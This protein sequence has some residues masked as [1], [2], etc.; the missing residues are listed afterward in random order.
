MRMFFSGQWHDRPEKI[1]VTNPYSGTVID[2]VPRGTV[3]DV[4]Q[5]LAT[6]VDGAKLMRAM[7]AY[8][9]SRI[10]RKAAA[11]MLEREADLGRTVSTEEGKILAEGIFEA[12]RARETIDV[13]AD[14]AKRLSSEV[15]PLDAA[16]GA[17]GKFGFTLRVPC[18]IVAAITPFNFP[19]NLVAHK[20]GPAIAAGNAVI[21]KPAS[22]TP[23]SA[24]KLVEILLEA[25]MPPQAIACITGGGAEIG[26]AL[27]TDKRVRKISFT[28]S[29]EVGEGICKMAGVKR[30]TME[31]GSNSPVIIMDDADLDKA[32]AMVTASGFANAGQVCISA[33]RILT[34]G[35]IYGDFLDA[36]KP[37]VEALTTGDQLAEATK[38]GPMIRERDAMRV[39]SWVNEAVGA[40]AKL[41]TGGKRHGT[42]YEATVLADVVP[43]MRISCDE[44]FG[45]AVAVTRTSD[46]DEAIRLANSTNYGLSASIFTRD[47]ERAMRFAREVDCGNLHVNWGTQWRADLAPYGGLKDSGIG[48]EGPHYAIREMSEEKM[49]VFHLNS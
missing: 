6:L 44:L 16:P 48:K 33:Q 13:S 28:G 39:E 34:D 19:L 1:N 7:P 25:G 24:L 9:R 21:I 31:L 11:L 43:S 36:L 35:S 30:V 17:K 45:P 5:A 32:A 23:L 15:I 37:R 3:A 29:Y 18:G 8:D 22:D 27:C 26:N 47:I 12:S 4:D 14:E 42:I 46:I 2:T 10:L 40:G 49:V 38:M 20:V 41:L